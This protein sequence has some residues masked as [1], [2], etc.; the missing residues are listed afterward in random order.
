MST[1]L[2]LPRELVCGTAGAC[3]QALLGS[4][5]ACT[6]W[7]PRLRPG[8]MCPCLLPE[9][10]RSATSLHHLDG[11]YLA[12]A[13]AWLQRQMR[14]HGTTPGDYEAGV[15]DSSMSQPRV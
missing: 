13:L 8:A 12:E 3:W 4:C 15:F 10:P 6:F 14:S 7:P 2:P 11:R 1:H 5:V 9:R